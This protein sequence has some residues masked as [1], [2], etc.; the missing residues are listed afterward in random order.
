MRATSV[1]SGPSASTSALAT[2]MPSATAMA[3]ACARPRDAEADRDRDRA[4]RADVPQ[5]AADSGRR[6]VRAP[7][8][9]ASETA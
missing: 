4:D 3:R 8:T 2:M 1:P 6:R 9:P 5:E 7:V